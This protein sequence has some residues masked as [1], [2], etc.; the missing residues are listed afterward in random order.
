[1]KSS[2]LLVALAAA[3][4]LPAQT[5][6]PPAVRPLTLPEAIAIAQRQGN[7]AQAAR[8]A[9][10]AARY[11]DRAFGARLALPQFSLEG[12]AV[13]YSSSIDPIDQPEGGTLFYR[14]KQ[15]RSAIGVRASQELPM[16]GSRL[17][18]SSGVSRI[19]QFN[20]NQTTQY[21]QTTP[22]EVGIEQDL[23]KPRSRLW[24]SREQDFA[25]SIAERQ[26]LE[27]REELATTTTT[28]FFDLYV[29]E[30]ALANGTA[31][32]AVNDTLYTLNKGRYEVGKIGENDLLQSELALLRART[33]L[34]GARLERDRAE[35]ALRR[36]LSLRPD[37][38]LA[39]LPPAEA[40]VIEVN[41]DVAVAAAQRNA[42]DL[43]QLD[44]QAT[45]ARR[46]VSEARFA[47][48]FSATVGAGYGYNQ[49]ASVFGDA[50]SSP[51]ARQRFSM[52][53]SMPFY[54]WGAGRADVQAARADEARIESLSRARRD[55]IQEEARFAALQLTQSQRMLAISAKADTVATK[56]FEVAKNRYVIG[57][58]GMSDLYIAQNEKDQ[59]LQA[60]VQALRGYWTAYYRLRRLTL[61][62]FEGR[63]EIRE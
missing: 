27:S 41:P 43:T 38:P 44:L 58:I 29:A 61:Y 13:N 50:Y 23:F 45:Q 31:N 56:R 32:A 25:I 46:R 36:L 7:Q 52:S 35:A 17:V 1:M 10:E 48:G 15:N 53:V 22:F 63:K 33:A 26:Y 11:R 51:L 8:S 12:D 2:V 30:V 60:Y 9:R 18:F 20:A 21:W 47:N 49:T 54:Q 39:V 28:A 62:D 59:A 40:P 5:P 4:A 34:D 6:S 16:T 24:A 55:A 14:R 19:D 37:Q 57:K 42:S 3:A